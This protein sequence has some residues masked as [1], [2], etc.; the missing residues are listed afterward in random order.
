MIFITDGPGFALLYLCFYCLEDV[1]C[2][3]TLL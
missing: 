2:D 3:W 1:F